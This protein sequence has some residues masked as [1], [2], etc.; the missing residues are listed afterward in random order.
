[1]I[2]IELGHAGAFRDVL[3]D[4][5]IGVLV[6]TSLPGVVRSGEVE[7]HLSR[8]LNGSVVMELGAIVGGDGL[9]VLGVLPDESDSA[10]TGLLLRPRPELTDEQVATLAL[11]QAHDAMLAA[12][13]HDGVDFPMAEGSARFNTVWSFADMSLAGEA[14]A[15]VIRAVALSALLSGAA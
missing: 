10:C 9:E 11:D 12:G 15:A 6:S 2:L 1:M 4:Q 13:A 5:A 7:G 8:T 3:S 14:A